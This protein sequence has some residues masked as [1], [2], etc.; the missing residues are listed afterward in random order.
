MSGT[1]QRGTVRTFEKPDLTERVSGYAPFPET[2][3]TGLFTGPRVEHNTFIR[4]IKE[5]RDYQQLPEAATVWAE[6]FTL[7]SAGAVSKRAQ[8]ACWKASAVLEPLYRCPLMMSVGDPVT[9]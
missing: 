4:G 9:L 7:H 5:K 3:V 6:R 8:I 1:D 2:P